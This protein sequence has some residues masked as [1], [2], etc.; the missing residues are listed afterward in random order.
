MEEEGDMR[1]ESTDKPVTSRPRRSFAGATNQQ[2]RYTNTGALPQVHMPPSPEPQQRLNLTR[3]RPAIAVTP[4][5]K[6][7]PRSTLLQTIKGRP[8]LTVHNT[9][10]NV[11]QSLTETEP[12]QNLNPIA[13]N[14]ALSLPMT[15]E[16]QTLEQVPL[17]D[18]GNESLEAF[19]TD[20]DEIDI[21]SGNRPA[22]I[23]SSMFFPEDRPQP[24]NTAATNTGPV[25]SF[26]NASSELPVNTRTPI[27]KMRTTYIRTHWQKACL[28]WRLSLNLPCLVTVY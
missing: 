7:P 2:V 19:M 24:I 21:A 9:P 6:T 10:Q 4:A 27:P 22:H 15:N 13:A 26:L 16:Y 17:V 20:T 11:T 1:I 18:L 8:S 25:S 12:T 3:N 14:T 28:H 5:N 23:E